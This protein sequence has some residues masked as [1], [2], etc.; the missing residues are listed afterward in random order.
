M[1]GN[2]TTD[3]QVTYRSFTTGGYVIQQSFIFSQNWPDGGVRPCRCL[4]QYYAYELGTADPIPGANPFG[5]NPTFL[6]HLATNIDGSHYGL[7]GQWELGNRGF[8]GFSFLNASN[9]LCF[10]YI[11]LADKCLDRRG[12]YWRAVF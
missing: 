10:G 4:P 7:A 2:G 8:A 11:E 6:T 3:I 1:D 12:H 9:V 5:Q